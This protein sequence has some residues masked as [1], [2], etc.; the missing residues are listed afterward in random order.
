VPQSVADCR[1]LS[2]QG[3]AALDRGQPE[4]AE[5][6]LAKAVKACPVDPEARRHYAES[7]WRRG[8]RKEAIAQMEE[9]CR[10]VSDDAALWT[11]IAQMRLADGQVELARQDADRAIDLDSKS[12]AAW[13]VRGGVMRVYGRPQQA[14]A[15][16]LRAMNYAPKDREILWAIAEL[17]RQQHQPERALLT[18]QSVADTYS[19]GEEPSHVFHAIGQT[20]VALGR[21]DE[22]VE[23]LTTAATRGKPTP[24]LLC[25]LGE[26]QLL[27]GHLDA[28]GVAASQSLA[29]APRHQASRELLDRLQLAQHADSTPRR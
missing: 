13:A 3:V 29:I 23:S 14:L 25:Q 9:A 24:D 20:Y 18:L 21:F 19:P 11:R 6:L 1:R 7:L 27:A 10:L 28:A 5:A 2:Q 26:A 17:Y 8:G 22:A 4:K 16:Y 15:D 12:A